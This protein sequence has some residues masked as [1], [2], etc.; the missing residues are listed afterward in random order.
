MLSPL[1]IKKQ[2]HFF[3]ILDFD[4]NGYIEEEDF[5]AIGENICIVRDF[6]I[7]TPEYNTIMK[8]CKGVWSNLIP[9]IDGNE[10]R[11]EEWLEFM[12]VL[13]DQKNESKYNK[14]IMNFTSVIFKMFDINGDNYISQLEYIDL[15][16]GMRIEVRFAPKAFKHLDENKDGK[17]SHDEVLASVN[18]FMKSENSKSSGN[19][20]F[21]GW[22]EMGI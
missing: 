5:E 19:W 13:L 10:G 4:N 2:T 11:L 21:G 7:D 6:D 15:F 12:T 1:Q 8:M 16:I 14:Y 18:D 9:Y 20:L 17:L 22:E 3:N